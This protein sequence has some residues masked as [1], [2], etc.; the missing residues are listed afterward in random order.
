[1]K[2]VV[3]MALGIFLALIV[4]SPVALG[5]VGHGALASGKAGGLAAD[6]WQWALAEPVSDNPLVGGDPNYSEDQ[7]DGQ[8]LSEVPGKKWF[9]AGSFD[10]S[11]VER[12]CTMP[13]GTQLFFPVGNVIYVNTDPTD[14]EQL[15]RDY[16]NGFIDSMLA[17]PEFEIR[18]TV[19]GKQI[20]SKRIV[21]TDSPL[22]TVTLPENS[23]FSR[24]GVPAGEYD[25]VADGL[26]AV[27][28]P[29]SKGEHTIHFEI[30]APSLDFS[31]GNTYHLSVE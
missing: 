3:L 9:L 29:L 25:A 4:A 5:Q 1:M 2:R 14:T 8:P 27:L 30:S 7:C 11:T 16:V 15:A 31:Q 21:R 13:V 6:W 18:V 22:F 20:K 19:D 23:L 24:F 28:P 12:T 17:D 10:G 26:W